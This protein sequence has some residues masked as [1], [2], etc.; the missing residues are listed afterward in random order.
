M[1]RI[2]T[3]KTKSDRGFASVTTIVSVIIIAVLVFATIS[4]AAFVMYGSGTG[5]FGS[6]QPGGEINSAFS[7]NNTSF[8]RMNSV[9][10]GV[11]VNNSSNTINVTS[12]SVTLTVGG[13]S[14]HV[15]NVI[16]VYEHKMN[17]GALP[18]HY[19]WI[20]QSIN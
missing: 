20:D 19:I 11:V 12:K 9:P 6:G 7:V 18:D 3:G 5:G 2:D 8:N 16:H 17:R 13:D 14:R 4:A 10:A 1:E 15:G